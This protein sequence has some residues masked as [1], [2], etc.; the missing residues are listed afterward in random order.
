MR[1]CQSG[2]RIVVTHENFEINLISLIFKKIDLSCFLQSIFFYTFLEYYYYPFLFYFV[3][4]KKRKIVHLQWQKPTLFNRILV[5]V[6]LL[7][8]KERKTIKTLLLC[9]LMYENGCGY[10]KRSPCI[11]V[12]NG[13]STALGSSFW[14]F[15]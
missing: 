2:M 14:I 5:K 10:S 1:I 15:I 7:K 11:H 4:S 6:D 9:G 13:V 3:N 8:K 12:W